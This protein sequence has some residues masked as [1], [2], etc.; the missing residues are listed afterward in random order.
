MAIL[1]VVDYLTLPQR[2]YPESLVLISLLEVYEEFGVK[3]GSTWRMLR[4]PDRRIA[5]HGHI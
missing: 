3:K 5:G 1:Y 2:R 4:V